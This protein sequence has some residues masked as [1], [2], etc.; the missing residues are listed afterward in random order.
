MTSAPPLEI[1]NTTE[2]ARDPLGR[3]WC[4][5]ECVPERWR[6]GCGDRSAVRHGLAASHVRT[7]QTAW[8]ARRTFRRVASLISY[9]RCGYPLTRRRG[10]GGGPGRR[11]APAAGAEVGQDHGHPHDGQGGAG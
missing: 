6:L 3:P 5:A 8:L 4:V 1:A 11:P 10:N 7:V 2:A 9:G